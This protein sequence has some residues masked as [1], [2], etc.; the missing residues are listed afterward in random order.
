[1]EH[2]YTQDQDRCKLVSTRPH[3]IKFLL[4]YSKSLN[5]VTHNGMA[6]ENNLN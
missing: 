3:R 6:F 5:V 2:I 1:M 4:D